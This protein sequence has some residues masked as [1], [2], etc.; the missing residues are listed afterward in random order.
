MFRI[1]ICGVMY[2]LA[3]Q[4]VSGGILGKRLFV[5]LRVF[6]CLAQREMQ[7]VAILVRQPV[8]GEERLHVVHLFGVEAK[9][10]EIRQ[11]PIGFA[12]SGRERDAL[13]IGGN[14]FALAPHGL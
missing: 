13:L 3:A 10:L 8:L 11:T 9:R 7:M 4:S 6:Q 5:A 12:E 2:G 1:F 14:A